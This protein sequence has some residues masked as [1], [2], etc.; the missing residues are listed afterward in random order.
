MVVHA[1]FNNEER[2]TNNFQLSV[3]AQL[4]LYQ[5]LHTPVNKP[6]V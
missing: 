6:K 3:F 5:L 2:I 4:A 1:F